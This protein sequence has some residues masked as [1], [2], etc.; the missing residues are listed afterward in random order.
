[1]EDGDKT[2][3]EAPWLSKHAVG[4]S[5]AARFVRRMSKARPSQPGKMVRDVGSAGI[6]V[7]GVAGNR[8]E[9]THPG[10]D[11]VDTPDDQGSEKAGSI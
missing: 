11:G 9:A 2:A 8:K 10:Y 5:R 3:G 1:M 7:Q 6:S 4:A